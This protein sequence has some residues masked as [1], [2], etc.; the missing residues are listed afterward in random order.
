MVSLIKPAILMTGT[1]RHI[2]RCGTVLAGS[3][4]IPPRSDKV[5]LYKDTVN[6]EIWQ[7]TVPANKS[8]LEKIWH[9]YLISDSL[10]VAS[11]NLVN[12]VWKTSIFI[13]LQ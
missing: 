2:T 8:V 13:I 1:D 9:R 12:K 3:Q 10:L 4:R 11:Y 6:N 7:I 5:K